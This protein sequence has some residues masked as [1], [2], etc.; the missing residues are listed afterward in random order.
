MT[1]TLD[2]VRILVVDDD[3]GVRESLRR[4]LIFNGYEV[5]LA[6]DG[7]RALSSIALRR[8]DAVVLDVMMPGI[9]G[10]ETCRRLRAADADDIDAVRSIHAGAA[11]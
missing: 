5:E 3:P 1:G 9:D 7:Q 8:P 4:S 10:L 11:G 2:G 6:E